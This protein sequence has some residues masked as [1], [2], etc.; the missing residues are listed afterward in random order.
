MT[1]LKV[2]IRSYFLP[3]PSTKVLKPGE[4]L[5]G[6]DPSCDI[7]IPDPYVSRKHLRI[8]HRD[9]KWYAVDMGSRNGTFVNGED[10]RGREPIELAPGIELVLGLTTIRILEIVSSEGSER[11]GGSEEG[12]GGRQS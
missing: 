9:G 12:G 11:G 8:F 4:Y 3:S 2:E 6:R 7:V 1:S 5:V 10:I